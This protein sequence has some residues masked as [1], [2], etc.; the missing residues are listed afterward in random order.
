MM[1]WD[2]ITA[3]LLFKEG[4]CITY[5]TNDGIYIGAEIVKVQCQICMEEFIGN[6]KAAGM[7]LSGHAEY[8]LYINEYAENHGGT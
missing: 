7:F 4:D 6:K 5:A 8:H 3:P 1:E 2:D